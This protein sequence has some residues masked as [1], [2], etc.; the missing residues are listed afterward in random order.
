VQVEWKRSGSVL[1]LTATVNNIISLNGVTSVL[2]ITDVAGYHR[3]LYYC[4]AKN[5]AGITISKYA[6]LIVLGN[7][8]T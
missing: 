5:K 3:G 2:T 1:P 7:Y 4:I 6:N 8:N